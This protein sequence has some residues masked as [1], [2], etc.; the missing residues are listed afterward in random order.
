MPCHGLLSKQGGIQLLFFQIHL[1]N[2]HLQS[3]YL[4]LDEPVTAT[5]D[6]IFF[7][8]PKKVKD[9]QDLLP[10]SSPNSDL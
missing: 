1:L 4:S 3:I 9:S 7:K 2:L 5:R 6:F 8:P 10:F